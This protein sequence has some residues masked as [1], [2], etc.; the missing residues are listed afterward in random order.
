MPDFNISSSGIQLTAGQS[1]TV[2]VTFSSLTGLSGTISN[3]SCSGLPAET[4]C[5]FNP[6]QVTLPSNGSVTTTLTVT[7]TAIGQSSKRAADNS[8]GRKILAAQA[9]ILLGVCLVAFPLSRRPRGVVLGAV[10]LAAIVVLPSCGGGG[11]GGGG[12]GSS[13]FPTPV[14]SS[15]NPTQVAAGSQ[16]QSLYINGSN[17]LDASTVTYN[18][19]LRNSSLQSSTQIQIA[20]E[21]TDVATTGQ[22]PVVVSNPTPGGGPSAPVNF[23][24]LSGTP[25]GTFFPYIN[26]TL[27]PITH[28]EELVLTIQ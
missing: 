13:T 1:Q 5:T 8:G 11:G 19:S 7:T 3:L 15:L 17:F 4:T 20:L 22:F 6:S 21:P 9:I 18:G 23:S 10:V 25:T 24:V 26:A 12:G 27:G 2:T 14:I 16:I 28:T